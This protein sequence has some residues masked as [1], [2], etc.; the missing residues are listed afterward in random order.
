MKKQRRSPH[1]NS[2]S[3]GL[4]VTQE[5]ENNMGE[6][7]CVWVTE[8]LQSPQ[9]KENTLTPISRGRLHI[10]STSIL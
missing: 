7:K 6:E 9:T 10:L 5:E 3:N 8:G 2:R 1:T 4:S